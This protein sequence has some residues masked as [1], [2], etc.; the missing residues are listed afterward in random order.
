MVIQGYARPE[1]LA[2]TEWLVEHLRDANLRIV[3]CDSP[4]AYNRAHIPGAVNVGTNP[5]V[6]AEDGASAYVMPPDEVSKFM[7]AL[8]IGDDT[9]VV[10][11][12]GRNSVGSARFWWVLNYYG[13]TNVK[14]LNGGWRKWLAEGR[15][16]TDRASAVERA[17]FTPRVD[18]SLIV[19]ADGLKLATGQEGVAI[20][21]VRSRGEYTGETTRGNKYGGHVPGCAYMEW[22]DVMDTAGLA[23]FKPAKDI[24]RMLSEI[25][26]TPDKQ[27]YTY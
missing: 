2:E 18:E 8:G 13:H 11:Y 27:V 17:S 24:R 5:N 22:T 21:D 20:W 15:P 10:T 1:L 23:T 26:V 3:D 4:D 12:D 9:L 14:V 7:S 19:N 6:K 25:G 16:V